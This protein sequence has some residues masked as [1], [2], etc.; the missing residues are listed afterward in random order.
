MVLTLKFTASA[1]QG[2]LGLRTVSKIKEMTFELNETNVIMNN[3]F[4]INQGNLKNLTH[5]KTS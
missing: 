3:P 4:Q 1:I 5:M 2:K